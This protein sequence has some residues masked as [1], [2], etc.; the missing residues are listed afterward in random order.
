MGESKHEWEYFQ[1]FTV[2]FRHEHRIYSQGFDC[3]GLCSRTRISRLYLFSVL[4]L[5]NIFE[6]FHPSSILTNCTEN[7]HLTC[8]FMVILF[9]IDDAFIKNMLI[10]ASKSF[11]LKDQR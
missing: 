6:R 10:R 2:K 4:S 7:V 8:M 3:R 11:S 9:V 5:V 1:D